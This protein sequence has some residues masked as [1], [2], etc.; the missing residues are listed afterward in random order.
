MTGILYEILIPHAAPVDEES[1]GAVFYARERFL[2]N[3]LVFLSKK[4]ASTRQMQ[5]SEIGSQNRFQ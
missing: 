4:N 1:A 2:E 5:A 3:Y